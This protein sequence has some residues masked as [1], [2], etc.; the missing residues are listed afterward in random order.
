MPI[1]TLREGSLG[2]LSRL[3]R[4]S[5]DLSRNA[6]NSD[7]TLPISSPVRFNQKYSFIC[8]HITEPILSLLHV[9]KKIG[10]QI[11]FSRIRQND[12]DSLSGIFPSLRIIYRGCDRRT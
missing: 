6:R 11:A 5:R 8:Y 12:D 7:T 9:V 3:C 10:A 2:G 4:F 1:S